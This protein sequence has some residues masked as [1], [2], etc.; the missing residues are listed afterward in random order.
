MLWLQYWRPN[1]W[2]FMNGDRIT[3]PT[4]RDHRDGRIRWLNAEVEEFPGLIHE[5]EVK[6]DQLAKEMK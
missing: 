4:A 6:V 2:A 1:N 3:Q 5:A